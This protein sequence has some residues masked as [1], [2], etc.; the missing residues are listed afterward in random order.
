MTERGGA[1]LLVDLYAAWDNIE[2]IDFSNLPDRFV[3]KANNGC[4]TVLLI[5]NKNEV[6]IRRIRKICKHWMKD[7][8]GYLTAEIQYPP[9]K[10]MIIAEQFLENDTPS[11]SSI[12][13]YKV[14]C[15]DGNP[16]CILV[17]ANRVIGEKAELAFYDLE[18]NKIPDMLSG[19]H[20][21]NDVSIEKPKCLK[22][23]LDAATLLAK[24]HPEVRVDFYIVN[25]R[26]FFGEM[27]FTSLG[28][29]MD[30]IAPKYLDEMGARVTLP[31][32]SI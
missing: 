30:Y 31:I 19:S 2:D 5:S 7:K 23:L 22:E 32:Q 6:S 17:C 18:W 27:T 1:D 10:P 13:D 28:G 11:S 29:Y 4:G 25:N 16:Y 12:V 3:L 15:L 9:I 21:A 24:G 26:V 8:F 14:F 20:K